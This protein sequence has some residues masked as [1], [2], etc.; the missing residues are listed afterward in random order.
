MRNLETIYTFILGALLLMLATGLVI[1]GLLFLFN[2]HF[3]ERLY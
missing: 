3:H 2:I 1:R